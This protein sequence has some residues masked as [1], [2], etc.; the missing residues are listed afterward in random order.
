MC[1]PHITGIGASPLVYELEWSFT[2]VVCTIFCILLGR[3]FNI[4]PLTAILNQYRALK[5][6]Y[7]MQ[8]PM[9]Y[10][11]LTSASAS[12]SA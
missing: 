4:Y 10:A 2:C 3:L 5:I 8:F 9:W 12:A 6:P 7:S 11:H 1:D